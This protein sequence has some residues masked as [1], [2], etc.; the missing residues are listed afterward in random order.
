[1]FHK[2]RQCSDSTTADRAPTSEV[3]FFSYCIIHEFK[4][5]NGRAKQWGFGSPLI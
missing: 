5:K 3:T 2:G 4:K 1:M